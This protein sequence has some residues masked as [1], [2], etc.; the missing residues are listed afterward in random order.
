MTGRQIPLDLEFGA[1]LLVHRGNGSTMRAFFAVPG[2]EVRRTGLTSSLVHLVVREGSG[3]SAHPSLVTPNSR[4]NGSQPGRIS[5]V[6][7][8]LRRAIG[9][10]GS[11]G[12]ADARHRRGCQKNRVHRFHVPGNVWWGR[13]QY[14]RE[15]AS[16]Q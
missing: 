1:K 10:L 6:L 9:S 4:R 12:E 16:E 11:S 13:L 14:G 7:L 3:R 15:I 2:P 8:N 5:S